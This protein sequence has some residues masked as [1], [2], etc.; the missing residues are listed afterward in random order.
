MKEIR[1]VLVVGA[2]VMGNGFAQV[3]ALNDLAVFLG[4]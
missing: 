3:F 2:G 4:L 1:D